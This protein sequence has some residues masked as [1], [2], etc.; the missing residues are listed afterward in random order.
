M[1]NNKEV[2]D[3]IYERML[4]ERQRL[5]AELQ[6]LQEQLQNLP[7]GKIFCTRNGNHY[8]W[9]HSDGKKQTY[10]PKKNRLLAEQLSIKK[11]LL[12]RIQETLHEI[13]A[14]DFYLRHHISNPSQAEL[15]L[16]S[17]PEYQE[18]LSPYFQ[19]QVQVHQEWMNVP[20]DRNMKYPE[21]LIHKSSSGNMVRSKSE[22]LIDMILHINNIPFRYEC[23]L[24]LGES[25]IYPD[26][27]ILHPH[28]MKIYYWEHM[29]LMD[30]PFYAQ[31]VPSKLQLYISNNIIPGIQLITTYETKD[32]PLSVEMV[33]GIVDYYFL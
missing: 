33:K 4:S 15:M 6:S 21:H 28:K 19:P 18:L 2:F 9:Y 3:T 8:K 16:T 13:N 17:H 12:L 7:E 31:K 24:Q 25:T 5:T 1:K 14:I 10:I 11:Y 32:N 23:A 30:N 27:T 29:G 26:F 22:A 20:Y